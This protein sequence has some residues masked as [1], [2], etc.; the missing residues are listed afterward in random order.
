MLEPSKAW[1]T[2]AWLQL[3][4]FALV[5]LG[6]LTFDIYLAH[7][8]NDFRK[9]PEYIPLYFSA[10]APIVLVIGLVLRRRWKAVWTD[11]GYLVGWGA[12]LVGLTGV[13]LHLDSSFFYER[14][15]K[16]L[17]YSAPFAAPLAYTGLGFLICAEPDGRPQVHRVGRVGS[18]AGPGGI[19]RE[20]CVQPLRPCGEWFLL[21][22]GVGGGGRE[23]SGSGIFGDSATGPRIAQIHLALCR[24]HAGSRHWWGFGDLCCT[25]RETCMGRPRILSRI[26]FT[27]HHLWR[28][29]CFP[30]SCCSD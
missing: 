7:S 12:I 4:V 24:D 20:L 22:H 10:L 9:A 5:N 18:V 16:S 28:R 19:C 27:V 23:R 14:T 30:I 2:E 17:T 15:I 26:S 13:I 3:E 1:W 25:P 8:I 11:L 21:S 6:F 29:C